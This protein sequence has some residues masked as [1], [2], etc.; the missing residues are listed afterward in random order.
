MQSVN[1]ELQSTNE[2]LE[3]SKE[4]LQSV[5]E[6]LGTVNSE[7]QTKVVDLSRVNN[8]MNNLLAG[9]GIGTV[10]VDHQLRILRFTP[11]ANAITNLILTD[12]GRPVSHIVSNLVGYDRLVADV[13][14]VLN[15]LPPKEVSVQTAD[16][17]WYTMRILPYRTLDNVIE[18]AVI[19]FVDVTETVQIREA[20]RDANELQRLA[21]VVRDAHDAITVQDLDG[22][23]LAWNP[24]AVRMYGWSEAEAL[25]MNVRERIPPTLRG[26]ALATL[27]QLSQA[28][29]LRPYLTERVTKRGDVM[30]VSIV[31]T[32][33]INDAGE[34][35]AIATTE[36]PTG[37]STQ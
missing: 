15:T 33:L 18:G 9:T 4:E 29:I 17:K 8:D 7:L 31:S 6:E 32:A 10:F 28:G 35:Y 12:I 23:I 11:A 25:L 36:R 1:E 26:Q 16:G 22:R 30:A 27:R 14:A 21:V 20:L 5:N 19:S 13:Q 3:T 37:G 2:E 24:G 34:V